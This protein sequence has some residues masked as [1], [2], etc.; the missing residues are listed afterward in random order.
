MLKRVGAMVLVAVMALMCLAGCGGGNKAAERDSFASQLY[1]AKNPYIS[2]SSANNELVQLTGA[3]SLGKY[4]LDIQDKKHP[5]TLS[6]RYMYLG[7]DVD[8]TS[9]ETQLLYTSIIVLSLI[10]DCEQVNW[11]FPSDDGLKEGWVGIDYANEVAGMDIKKAAK[12]QES[13]T[14]LCD[15][16]FPNEAVAQTETQ[17]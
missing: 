17:E 10:D 14:T 6:I 9:V 8:A 16:L 5:Y 4:N 12:D 1:A 11:S 7:N 13:F 2:N 3:K 15:T